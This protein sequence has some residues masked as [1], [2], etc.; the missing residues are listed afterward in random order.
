MQ[1]YFTDLSHIIILSSQEV[2]KN[3]RLPYFFLWRPITT[4]DSPID[5]DWM[6]NDKKNGWAGKEGGKGNTKEEVEKERV[7]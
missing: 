4:P 2:P 7:P 5:R 1:F 6:V 3:N